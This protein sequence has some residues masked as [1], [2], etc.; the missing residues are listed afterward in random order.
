MPG[1]KD[2][3][4]LIQALTYNNIRLNEGDNRK[5]VLSDLAEMN[6]LAGKNANTRIAARLKD[7]QRLVDSGI[8]PA[9]I[10]PPEIKIKG[11]QNK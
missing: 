3:P 1:A 11:T 10:C 5:R 9:D 6:G 4:R 8:I 7:A 2:M